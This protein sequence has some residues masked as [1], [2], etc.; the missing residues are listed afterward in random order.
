LLIS[1]LVFSNDQA[2]PFFWLPRQ[3]G[4]LSRPRHAGS[5]S[6]KHQDNRQYKMQLFA[7]FLSVISETFPRKTDAYQKMLSSTTV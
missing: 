2:P 1:G 4:D 7:T 5:V 3:W 6:G